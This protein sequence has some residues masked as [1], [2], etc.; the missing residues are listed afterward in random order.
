M[1]ADKFFALSTLICFHL[2]PKYLTDSRL[3]YC[4]ALVMKASTSCFSL[5]LESLSM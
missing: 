4:S 5:P 3:A 1:N 2:R